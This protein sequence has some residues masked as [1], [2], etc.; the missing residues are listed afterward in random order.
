MPPNVTMNEVRA[1]LTILLVALAVQVLFVYV[2]DKVRHRD[3]WD[4]G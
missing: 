1:T 4:K 2:F 3:P